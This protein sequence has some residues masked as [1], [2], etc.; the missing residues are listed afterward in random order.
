[1]RGSKVRSHYLGG[2]LLSAAAALM[3]SACGQA[4]DTQSGNGVKPAPSADAVVPIAPTDF[5]IAPCAGVAEGAKCAIIA[6]GGKRVLIGAPAGIGE[7]MI[8]GDVTS[9]DGVVLLS[10]QAGAVEGLDELRNHR[11]TS[12]Q[13]AALVIAGAQGV[14]SLVAGLNA[15]YVTSDALAYVSGD[16]EGG[17]DTVPIVAKVVGAGEP[18]FDTGDLVIRTYAG[19]PGTLALFV[20]YN[21]KTALL[22]DC[23]ATPADIQSWPS[24]D[25]YIGC[26][27]RADHVSDRQVDFPPQ[28]R[29][30]VD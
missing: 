14:D 26:V 9:P 21:D 8:A 6:A 4:P 12:G 16:R 3:L 24:A 27:G 29:I 18:A 23:A 19:G 2:W 28:L 25:V 1:M 20:T 15:A 5:V 17:F 13:R 11:W 22:S 30:Y 7:G 10:L